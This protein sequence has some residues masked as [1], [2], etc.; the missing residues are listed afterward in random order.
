VR[1]RLAA[2]ACA[3]ALALLLASCASPPDEGGPDPGLRGQ[4]ELQSATDAAGAIPIANQLISLT[5][6]GDT[7]TTG[8]SACSDYSAHVYGTVSN[9]WV[10]ATLPRAENCGIQAQEDIEHRYIDD[11]NQVRT[12]TLD[13][14]VL[15]LLAPGIDLRF[16]RALAVPT[17]LIVNRT[18]RLQTVRADSYY[19]NS[20]SAYVNISGAS[21][22][23]GSDGS[24]TGTTGCHRFTAKYQQNAGEIVAQHIVEHASGDCAG[25][26]S[27]ADV[28]LLQVIKAGFTFFS[29]SGALSISSP[30]AELSL[31]FVD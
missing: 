17:T 7:T 15:D 12:S 29:E 14:G 23:L 5:I 10:T 9:L 28:I 27:T 6:D 2:I 21:L 31:T 19:G 3:A 26:S 22:V 11:L 16:A 4:W 30:R 25:T 13:G 8:R 20:N 18:W 24:L 1:T